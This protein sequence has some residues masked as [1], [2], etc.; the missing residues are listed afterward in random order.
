VISQY[1]SIPIPASHGTDMA[2][3]LGLMWL[4]SLLAFI[5]AAFSQLVS[6]GLWRL[7]AVAA[8]VVALMLLAVCTHG[9]TASSPKHTASRDAGPER[10]S[11]V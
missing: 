9:A 11:Y 1:S 3:R 2:H 6:E 7:A 5:V 10:S 8:V 4:V